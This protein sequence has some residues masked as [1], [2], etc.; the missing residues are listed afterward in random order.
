MLASCALHIRFELTV[1]EIHKDRSLSRQESLPVLF[2]DEVVGPA[3]RVPLFHVGLLT[4]LVAVF[5][6]VLQQHRQH[7]LGIVLSEALELDSLPGNL[8]LEVPR[9]LG[10]LLT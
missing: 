6:H 3:T 8:V 9:S 5:V 7:L 1:E 2:G 10:G 4:D